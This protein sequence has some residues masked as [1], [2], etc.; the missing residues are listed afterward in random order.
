[1]MNNTNV[2]QKTPERLKSLDILRGFDMFWIIGGGSLI[3]AISEATEWSWLA[4]IATQ[5]SH[6]EWIGFR[7][8]DLIF[9]LFMFIT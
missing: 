1:M 3:I 2:Y 6:V 4:P 9:H 7:F 5:M 8:W